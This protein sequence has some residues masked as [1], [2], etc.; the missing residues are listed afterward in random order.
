MTF[1]SKF[2]IQT[3]LVYT[4]LLFSGTAEHDV[5]LYFTYTV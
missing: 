5:F 3:D 1:S 2:D 4:L